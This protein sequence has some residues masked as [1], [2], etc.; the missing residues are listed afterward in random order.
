MLHRPDVSNFCLTA[1]SMQRR[2]STVRRTTGVGGQSRCLAPSNSRKPRPQPTLDATY[3]HVS[4]VSCPCTYCIGA[5]RLPLPGRGG[6]PPRFPPAPKP[7]ARC[8]YLPHDEYRLQSTTGTPVQLVYPSTQEERLLLR[9]LGDIGVY[10]SLPR[11]VGC[12]VGWSRS[13]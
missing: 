6:F 11:L 9:R 3:T 5:F 7:V 1:I 12:W 8:C 13:T 4:T 2:A 10:G